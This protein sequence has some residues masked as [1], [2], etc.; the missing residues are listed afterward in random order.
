MA[1]PVIHRRTLLAGLAAAA[2]APAVL[3]SIAAGSHLGPEG[4]MT[5]RY[6]ILLSRTQWRDLHGRDALRVPGGVDLS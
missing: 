2:V 3:H 1:V 6:L 5:D 4:W